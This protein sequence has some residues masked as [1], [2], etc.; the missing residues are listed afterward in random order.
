MRLFEHQH[1][2]LLFLLSHSS[3]STLLYFP[4]SF[5]Q[6]YLA[7]CYP[8]V[9][10]LCLPRSILETSPETS[11]FLTNDYYSSLVFF[12]RFLLISPWPSFPEITGLRSP[13]W[14]ML[15]REVGLSISKETLTQTHHV[16]SPEEETHAIAAPCWNLHVQTRLYSHLVYVH[17]WPKRCLK[18]IVFV[19]SYHPS[20]WTHLWVSH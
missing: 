9:L 18:C 17:C 2:S 5:G 16:Q 15:Q 20:L 7:G 13:A 14:E 3:S 8:G 10:L 1:H 12:S 11:H 19:L 4:L 6:S